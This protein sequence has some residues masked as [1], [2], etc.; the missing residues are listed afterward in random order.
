MNVDDEFS[1]ELEALIAIFG[2]D[3][4]VDM[5]EKGARICVKMNRFSV[6]IHANRNYIEAKTLPKVQIDGMR[7]KGDSE[8]F[9]SKVE[10]ET[11]L[12]G[13]VLFDMLSRIQSELNEYMVDE[14]KGE[15]R[16]KDEQE[17]A[18]GLR[19]YNYHHIYSKKKIAKMNEY[20]TDLRLVGFICTGKPGYVLIEGSESD[21]KEWNKRVRALSWQHM[22]LSFQ[23]ISK[24]RRLKS[25]ET[26]EDLKLNEVV[27]FLEKY[28]LDEISSTLFQ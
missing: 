10:Q 1:L 13:P 6:T 5:L 19:F 7:T 26:F 24:E 28:Q 20:A 4:I 23:Q 22:A 18:F 3:I 12:E 11:E 2:A 21:V 17:E 16:E 15:E 25:L 8:A 9:V 14:E 27:P